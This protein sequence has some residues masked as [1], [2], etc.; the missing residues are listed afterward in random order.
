MQIELGAP[1]TAARRSPVGVL[2][3][4]ARVSGNGGTSMVNIRRN[5][6]LVSKTW[7][8]RLERSPT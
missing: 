4:T 2:P 6:P 1:I 8:R 3:L 7:M 5:L